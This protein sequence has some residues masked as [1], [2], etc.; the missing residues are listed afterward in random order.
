MSASSSLDTSLRKR[1]SNKANSS[2]SGSGAGG[3]AGEK[4]EHSD[5]SGDGLF[6]PYMS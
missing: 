2:G 5:V 6:V 4:K 1:S 3:S